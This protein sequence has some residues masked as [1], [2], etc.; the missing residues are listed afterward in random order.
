MAKRPRAH[1]ANP[2]WAFSKRHWAALAVM[3]T[4]FLA[5]CLTIGSWANLDRFSSSPVAYLIFVIM[6]ALTLCTIFALAIG[7]QIARL[8]IVSLAVCAGLFVFTCAAI[9]RGHTATDSETVFSVQ[10]AI[11]FSIVTWTT[12]GYGDY[13]PPPDLQ[14][15]AAV[16]AVF[17]YLYLGLLV[18]AVGGLFS[19][20]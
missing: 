1:S 19:R 18:G 3:A 7:E 20:K 11:Y 5:T 2:I 16:Q 8:S 15:M 9:Y 14:I 17:G 13:K 12:L 10:E 4:V 6:S